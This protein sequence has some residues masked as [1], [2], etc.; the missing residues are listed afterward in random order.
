MSTFK[1]EKR[2]EIHACLL[3]AV[4]IAVGTL[5]CSTAV[6]A[7][8][9][10]TLGELGFESFENTLTANE[11]GSPATQ[12]GSHPYQMT[13]SFL[14]KRI[15]KGQPN[16]QDAE[17]GNPKDVQVNLPVGLVGDPT[18]TPRCTE[19]EFTTQTT[20]NAS[21]QHAACPDATAVGWANLGETIVPQFV[22]VY[23]L[24]PPAGVPAMIG[25]NPAGL[26]P[27]RID[28]GVRT[29]GDYGVTASIHNISQ[30]EPVYTASV[31]LWGVPAD[32]SHDAL[33]GGCI[34]P[35]TG[36]SE[37]V[38]PANVA[39]KPFLTLPTSCPGTLKTSIVADSW[40]EPG[41][42]D[43]AGLPDL[44][45]PRWKTDTYSSPNGV[46]GCEAL[47]FSPT[48]TVKPDTSA[49]DSPSG[50]TVDLAV[51]QNDN[52]GGLAEAN[53]KGAA[54]TLPSGMAVNPAA[55]DGLASCSEAQIG[56]STPVQPDCPDA[57]TIGAVEVETP[58]LPDPLKGSVYLA[59]QGNRPGGGTNPFGSLL[60][61]YVVASGDG[62]LVKLA[63]HVEA[64]PNTGQL[65]TTFEN[66]PQL[67]FSNLK[68]SLFGGSR[69]VLVTPAAC[70][71]YTSTSTL[72]P[73]SGIPGLTSFDGFS[74]ITGCGGGFSPSF[75]AGTSTNQAGGYSPLS[76]TFSRQ[77]GEQRL[78]GITMRMPP[79]LLAKIAGIPLCG[80]AQANTGTC[81]PASQI[82]A[83]TAGAGAGP[84]PFFVPE[85]GQP[86]NPVYLT[87]PYRGAPFGL[88]I[89]THALAGPFDLGNVIVRAA[90]EID[91]HTA[92]I[93]VVSDA[94]PRI[95]E[96]VPLD[97]RTVNVEV[98]RPGFVF[99]PTSCEPMG[100]GADIMSQ[101]DSAVAVASSYQASNCAALAF[102][103][104][105]L[106]L[107]QGKT[108]KAAG[109]ALDVKVAQRPG[110]ADIR[111][112]DLTLPAALPARLTTLQ[113]ACTEAQ[114]NS[115]P[116]GCPPG[117]VIGTATAVSPLLNVP[118]TG[119]AILVSHGGA[120]FPDVLFLLQ[121]EGVRIELDG[122]TDIK[123]GITY[124]RF[125]TVPDAPIS[126]FE[127]TLPE[128]PHSA[129]A[130][131]VNLCEQKLVMPTTIV[132]QNG[133]VS[134]QNTSIEAQGC[135][136]AIAIV[137]HSLKRGAVILTVAV[138][139]AGRL[140]GK[141]VGLSGASRS[142]D[143]RE[144]LKLTLRR[145]GIGRKRT[146]VKLS[147]AP[148]KGKRLSKSLSVKL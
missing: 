82:G 58:V 120:A 116:A 42:V 47:D 127:A 79:G 140:S 138:P 135:P 65:Q 56:L 68:L 46:S 121:G 21:N 94:L 91:P 100:V 95:L 17:G 96:G 31:T 125:E 28:V 78:G 72:T 98:D 6:P 131:N 2:V 143:G 123:K 133:A 103:P 54:V 39:P 93:T 41:R 124:S 45:D 74:V 10:E 118:L 14:L 122:G 115:N 106:A 114:F 126:S 69:G 109:A 57:S 148:K 107:T 53:L 87:G 141:G 81:S 86:T 144:A 1:F 4:M 32:P 70:G 84:N 101:E 67:P 38:C 9:S 3:V 129:L 44:S 12:A 117:S 110:E 102:K 85:A 146:T 113:K 8:A 73:W 49:A 128:G 11:G 37:G 90:I 97:L 92:Q 80:E 139:A 5:A 18:A 19:A 89:V 111:K 20:G 15:P 16:E 132:G 75:A 105:F 64:N 59:Q 24:V 145:R 7:R 52:P 142:S 51:P 136:D 62:V 26:A 112:V 88:S 48:I 83:V 99:N 40:L 23:N 13:T 76:V 34:S 27:V 108:S 77:D 130:A 63:G 30:A 33:R 147:F 119:P 36:A 60:A 104:S 137:S 66:N 22:P 43:S 25:F 61:V 55:A 50:L 29:G 35:L 71:T 134:R